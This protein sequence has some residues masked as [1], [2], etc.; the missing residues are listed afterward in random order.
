MINQEELFQAIQKEDLKEEKMLDT[1]ELF[2]LFFEKY[3]KYSQQV[4]PLQND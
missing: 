1:K 4:A 3:P 2:E